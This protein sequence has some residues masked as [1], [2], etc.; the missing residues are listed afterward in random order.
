MGSM[1]CLILFIRTYANYR[2]SKN[3]LSKYLAWFALL[4]CI[5]QFLFAAPPFFTLDAGTLRKTYLAGELFVY[6]SAIAQSALLWCLILRKH[7][8]I[9]AV[10]LPVTLVGAVSWIYAVPRSTLGLDAGSFITYRDPTFSTIVAG[11]VLL[12]LFI[13]VGLYFL[14]SASQQEHPKGVLMSLTLG[15]VYVGVGCF[16]GGMELLAGQVMT[17]RSAVFDLAFFFVMFSVFLWPRRSPAKV[18]RDMSQGA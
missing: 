5:G 8:P 15:L 4:M 2:T 10:T 12:G 14:H 3:E 7:L 17:P 11:V 18:V 16:T 1:A 13:P 9:Y 6:G